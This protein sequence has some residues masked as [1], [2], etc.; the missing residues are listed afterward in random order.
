MTNL[1]LYTVSLIPHKLE[2]DVMGQK[3]LITTDRIEHN[4]ELSADRFALP[5]E[6]RAIVDEGEGEAAAE[7]ESTSE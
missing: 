1:T 2:V 7:V 6:I 3:R 4:V 5:P